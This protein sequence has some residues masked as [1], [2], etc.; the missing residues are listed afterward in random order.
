MSLNTICKLFVLNRCRGLGSEIIEDAVD[1][2]NLG[3]NALHQVVDQ[4]CGQVLDSDLHDVGGVDGADDA[5]PVKCALAVFDAGGLEVRNDG[6]VLPYLA[7][8]AV[9]C[10]LLAED[11]V[12]LADSFETVAGD[13]AG[14]ADAQAG[15]GERLTVNHI[16]GKAQSSS[17]FADFVLEEGQDRLNQLELQILGKAACVVVSLDAGLTLQDVGPDSSLCKEFDSV[18]LS[19]FLSEDFDELAADDVSLLLGIR[20]AC[21]LIQEAVGSIYVDEVGVHLITEYFDNLLGLA[22]A[23]QSVVDMYT[24]EVLADGLDQEGCN[25][26]GIYTAGECQENLL[27]SYLLLDLFDLLIDESLRQSGRSDSFHV[28]RAS[29][30]LHKLSSPFRGGSVIHSISSSLSILSEVSHACMGSVW[31]TMSLF[32]IILNKDS[33]KGAL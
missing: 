1:A 5:G 28:F 20:D 4:L 23:E 14:A 9:L 16:G 25:D 27:V 13:G 33:T 22:L 29:A 21:Q 30:C 19:G 26:G 18:E 15:A 10:E 6:E 8:E 12:G 31:F 2:G 7:F 3:D 17:D 32:I 11:S 24:N